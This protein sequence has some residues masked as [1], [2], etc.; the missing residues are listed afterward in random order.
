VLG[1][2]EGALPRY[3]DVVVPPEPRAVAEAA[4]A[5]SRREVAIEPVEEIAKRVLRLYE[6]ARSP[7]GERA[8]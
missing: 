7:G 5:Q 6:G 1:V 3:A 8:Q 2:A 4:L